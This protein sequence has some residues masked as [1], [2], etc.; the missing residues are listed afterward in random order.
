MLHKELPPLALQLREATKAAHRSLDH[1]PLLAALV[2][3][4]L[5]V[6]DYARALAA[7]HGA[8][9]AIE[10]ALAGFSPEE[11]FPRR[12]L[13]LEADLAEL[14]CRPI[15]L[16][17]PPPLATTD[18]ARIGL[19]YVLEGSNLGGAVIA[20]LLDTSLTKSAPRRFFGRTG[21]EERWGRFWDFA[22]QRCPG[23]QFNVAC[24]AASATFLFYRR[25]LDGCTLR[26][27]SC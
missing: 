22:L 19:M 15:D 11:I 21:G 7:L 25:H 20:R 14:S 1:H 16:E 6:S 12:L 2:S 4:K 17:T 5:A 9:A 8:H 26:Q 13:N 24:E 10:T 23:D 27:R 3:Q 18:A